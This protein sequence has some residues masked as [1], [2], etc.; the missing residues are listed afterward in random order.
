MNFRF[1]H[2]AGH[3]PSVVASV[4]IAAAFGTAGATYAAGSHGGGHHD[5]PNI[6]RPGDRS[7]ATRTVTVVMHD[8]YYEPSSLSVEPGETVHFV[9]T[10]EGEFV[11]EF[12]IGTAG[13][14]QAHGPEMQMMMDHGALTATGIDMAAAKTM[15]DMMGHGMHDDPNSVLLEPGDTADLTWTFPR[16][17]IVAL[18]F[19]CNVPGH[20][21][22]GMVG[23]F[24]QMNR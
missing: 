19:A 22:S 2:A 12:N 21:E 8:N 24:G 10:N 3:R 20:R 18:Q 17:G 7:A 11:H 16:G 6:G 14:H 23:H 4:L 15:Q 9:V 5:G 13:M 1:F